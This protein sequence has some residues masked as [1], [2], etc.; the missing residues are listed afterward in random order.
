MGGKF[1]HLAKGKTP[2]IVSLQW[3]LLR[4]LWR[5][6]LALD[7]GLGFSFGSMAMKLSERTTFVRL[8]VARLH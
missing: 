3:S 1:A 2:K 4:S 6:W 7:L 5:V 8:A